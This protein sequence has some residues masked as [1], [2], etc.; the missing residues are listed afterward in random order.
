MQI[1]RTAVQAVSSDKVISP[2]GA[3]KQFPPRYAGARIP[4]GDAV[5]AEESLFCPQC[6]EPLVTAERAAVLLGISRRAI[7]RLTEDGKVHYAETADG[8]LEVCL[9]SMPGKSDPG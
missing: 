9:Y 6:A 5:N 1:I 4:S 3:G 8:V 7:Y 2:A